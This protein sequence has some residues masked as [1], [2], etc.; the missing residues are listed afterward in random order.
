MKKFIPIIAIILICTTLSGCMPGQSVSAPPGAIPLD[1]MPS[2]PPGLIEPEI[3]ASISVSYA[4][5]PDAVSVMSAAIAGDMN[6][7]AEQ[8]VQNIGDYNVSA[9][10][11]LGNSGLLIS[12]K[13]SSSVRAI[14]PYDDYFVMISG[15]G[16][17]V[18]LLLS[19][20]TVE[21]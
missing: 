7:F 14:V 12:S 2:I 4:V 18:I 19:E 10:Q 17:D 3:H 6:R 5:A 15:A 11:F 21:S 8:Y 16:N 20:F 9:V 1:Q 13:V